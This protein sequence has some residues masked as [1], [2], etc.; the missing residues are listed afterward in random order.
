M[1]TSV[2][3]SIFITLLSSLDA[4]DAHNRLLKL[5]LKRSQDHEISHVLLRCA[6]G[7]DPYNPYY[8][9]VAKRLC[10]QT[11]MKKAF[12]FALWGW[13][14][15]RLGEKMDAGEEGSDDDDDDLLADKDSNTVKMSEIAN[16]SRLFANLI[17]DG[18]QSL[19]VLRVLDLV[20]I[21]ERTSM[22]VELLLVLIFTEAH[23]NAKRIPP[24]A[25]LHTWRFSLRKRL[26]G[27]MKGQLS[28]LPRS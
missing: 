1:N 19:G 21:K 18:S 28:T 14:R 6:A 23:S 26:V 2:R 24:Q 13:W 9:L 17:L 8:A 4:M 7:E 25:P 20:Y 10:M 16:L 12:Q 3:R 5:R 22:F 27:P 11:R 15:T